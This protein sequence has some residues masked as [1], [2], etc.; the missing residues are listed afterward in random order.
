ME[1]DHKQHDEAAGRKRQRPHADDTGGDDEA[2]AEAKAKHASKEG[3]DRINATPLHA[4]P[5]PSSSSS[6][7]AAPAAVVAVPSPL[8]R[9]EAYGAAAAAVSGVSL[10]RGFDEG[11]AMRLFRPEHA[12]ASDQQ[13]LAMLPGVSIVERVLSSCGSG[14]GQLA[15]WDRRMPAARKAVVWLFVQVSTQR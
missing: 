14:A 6:A 1:D 11:L 5:S 15:S 8:S 12:G 7:A 13:R 4:L 3:S 10:V 9:E 2:A